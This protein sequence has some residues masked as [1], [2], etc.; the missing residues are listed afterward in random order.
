[1]KITVV[2]PFVSSFDGF[3]KT[4]IIG[5]ACKA[6]YIQ[7]NFVNPRDF[8]DDSYGS[9]DDAP[10]GGGAGMVMKA[11]PY[12][13]AI[14][15]TEKIHSKGYRVLLTPSGYRLT[16]SMVK[17]LSGEP[18]LVLIC[19]HYEGIDARV[20]ELAVDEEISI[21]DFVLSGGELGAMVVI[22]AVSRYLPN[23]LGDEDSVKDESF[24]IQRVEH[25]HYT[26]PVS[27]QG[28]EVPDV[29]L[30]GN[31]EAIAQFRNQQ[32]LERTQ[33]Y[34]PDLLQSDASRTYV[35][36]KT[37]TDIKHQTAR[38][39]SQVVSSFGLLGCFVLSKEQKVP[40]GFHVRPSMDE[41]YTYVQQQHNDVLPYQIPWAW[42]GFRQEQIAAQLAQKTP[43]TPFL[44]CFDTNYTMERL[45]QAWCCDEKHLP[46]FVSIVLARLFGDVFL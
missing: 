14:A 36:W 20:C 18:H 28:K 34:R 44:V 11:E 23:V 30:S 33:H 10:Y 27:V 40:H 7:V 24:S 16:Q 9:I 21:G 5:R 46:M 41:I 6:G 13:A 15:H 35:V 38:M 12:L 22:D 2:T 8:V 17:R 45:S 26:R 1:M 32:S 3:L 37:K 4:S 39:L 43:E 25:P 42:D 31:H 29:L 19:G